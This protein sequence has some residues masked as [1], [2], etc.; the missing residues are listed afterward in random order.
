MSAH[1]IDIPIFVI[2]DIFYAS[3]WPFASLSL[4]SSRAVTA[5]TAAA[6]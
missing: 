6:P 5:V 4:C 3:A 1:K 2:A